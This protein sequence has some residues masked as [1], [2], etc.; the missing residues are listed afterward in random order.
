DAAGL[1]RLRHPR[2]AAAPRGDRRCAGHRADR[3]ARRGR[4]DQG[5][6]AGRGRLRHQAVQPQGTGAARRSGPAPRA[7]AAGRRR[8][9]HAHRWPDRRGPGRAPRRRGRPPRRAHAHRVPPAGHADGAAG[10]GAEPAAVARGRVGHPRAHRD[11]HRGH[12]RAAA[13]CQAGSRREVDRDG[14]RLRLSVQGQGSGEMSARLRLRWLVVAGFIASATGAA[15]ILYLRVPAL[16][17]ERLAGRLP[18]AD[19]DALV[20]A[21]RLNVLLAAALGLVLALVLALWMTGALAAAHARLRADVL[22][23][24]REPAPP[25]SL[26]QAFRELEPRAGAAAREREDLAVLPASV[27]AGIVPLG[28]GGRLVRV[29]PAARRLLGLPAGA[30]GQPISALVRHVE[31]R[32]AITHALAGGAGEPT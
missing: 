9:A 29:N 23:L 20:G 16:A 22:R 30:E 7:G 18:A 13:A 6:R 26:P 2:R 11:A 32:E 15:L 14:A 1:L 27:T 25:A 8:R 19:L 12:A 31:L 10:P 3:A 5:P 4:P 17:R 28:T 21:L 24:A